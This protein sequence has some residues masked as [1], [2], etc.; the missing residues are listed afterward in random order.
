MHSPRTEN[1]SYLRLFFRFTLFELRPNPSYQRKSVP[2]AQPYGFRLSPERRLLPNPSNPQR[3]PTDLPPSRAYCRT[4]SRPVY[5]ELPDRRGDSRIAPAVHKTYAR[6]PFPKYTSLPARRPPPVSLPARHRPASLSFGNASGPAGPLR[7]W[8][9]PKVSF[10][11]SP[12]AP[13]F[14]PLPFFLSVKP[15]LE[16]PSGRANRALAQ[17]KN[18]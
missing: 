4:F 14:Y 10:S 11:S 12:T 8:P 6:P 7:V 18:S 13:A 15:G 9:A 5:Q 3:R 1:P 17:A 16:L 2:I